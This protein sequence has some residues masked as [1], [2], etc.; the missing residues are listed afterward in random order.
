MEFDRRLGDIEP[1]GDRLVG[2]P[3]VEQSE[4]LR[5][6]RTEDA[7]RRHRATPAREAREEVR[8]RR[9][10]PA[11]TRAPDDG[12][13]RVGERRPL[14]VHLL[15]LAARPSELGRS[16]QGRE[17][18]GRVSSGMRRL[19]REQMGAQQ[20]LLAGGHAAPAVRELGQHAP[21]RVD[22]AGPQAQPCGRHG[23]FVAL[24]RGRHDR[25]VRKIGS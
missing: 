3:F 15:H 20:K 19:H 10:Q 24:A 25:G 5:L 11:D 16:L 8:G 9:G 13:D 6:A 2:E 18:R 14:V 12:A 17:G 4:D 23:G 22:V 7:A 21:R 1:T